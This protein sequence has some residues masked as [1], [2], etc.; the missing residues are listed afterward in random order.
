M[1]N[2]VV[3][4]SGIIIYKTYIKKAESFGMMFF[5]ITIFLWFLLKFYFLFSFA[6]SLFLSQQFLMNENEITKKKNKKM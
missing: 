6:N 2:I 1:K 5:S 3:Y 4:F